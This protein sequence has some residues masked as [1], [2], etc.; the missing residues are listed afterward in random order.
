[1]TTTANTKKWPKESEVDSFFGRLELGPDG[2]PTERWK[3]GNLTIAR[4]PFH[5]RMP[6]D[7]G[8]TIRSFQCHKAVRV[9]IETIYDKIW[10]HYGRD[11]KAIR[12]A[13]VDIFGGCYSFRRNAGGAKLSMHCWGAAV[14][15]DPERNPTGEKWKPN[16]GMMP[17]AVVDI[18]NEFGWEWGGDWKNPT[19]PQLFQAARHK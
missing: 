2:L 13:R 15:I 1:M 19:D 10:N 5:L 16:T 12:E 6:W 9:S 3:H 11:L 7:H 4:V 17:E 18:F 14:D 8:I